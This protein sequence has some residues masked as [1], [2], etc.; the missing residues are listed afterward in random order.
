M[1]MFRREEMERQCLVR[2]RIMNWR[3]SLGN[4]ISLRSPSQT[5]LALDA[6]CIGTS[7]RNYP[8]SIVTAI[9]IARGKVLQ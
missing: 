6:V 9:M 2:I 5:L 8:S 1:I 3:S 7:K 4:V